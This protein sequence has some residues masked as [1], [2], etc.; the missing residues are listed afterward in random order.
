ML[1]ANR[2]DLIL[3]V[4]KQQKNIHIG[5]FRIPRD[6]RQCVTSRYCIVPL[7]PLSESDV[8]RAAII[9]YAKEAWRGP[10][11]RV[12][13]HAI[14][15]FISFVVLL[16]CT[17]AQAQEFPVI[18]ARVPAYVMGTSSGTQQCETGTVHHDPCTTMNIRGHRVTI[19]W[20]QQTKDVTY[21]FTDD[22]RLSAI[23]NSESA[24]PVALPTVG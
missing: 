23:V 5:L 21:L 14:R 18:G 4:G 2:N 6:L 3:S 12:H 17:G 13:P 9:R 19:A 22:R 10:G 11:L 15:L 24:A 20:D 7:P 1:V 8:R 16:L